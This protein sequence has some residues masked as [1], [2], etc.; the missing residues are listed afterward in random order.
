[1]NFIFSF[2]FTNLNR[3]KVQKFKKCLCSRTELWWCCHKLRQIHVVKEGL[4][5]LY[6]LKSEIEWRVI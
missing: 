4:R 6:T 3:N 2:K 5:L 1:M